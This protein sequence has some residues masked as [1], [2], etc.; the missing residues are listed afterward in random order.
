MVPGITHL[1]VK[2][3][4]EQCLENILEIQEL[5]YI[6]LYILLIHMREYSHF[7]L[8]MVELVVVMQYHKI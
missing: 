4:T 8:M 6:I 7:M 5:K 2:K 1:F 3:Y